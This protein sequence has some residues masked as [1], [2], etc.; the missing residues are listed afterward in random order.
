MHDDFLVIFG[1]LRPT[2]CNVLISLPLYVYVPY[3]KNIC[4][5]EHTLNTIDFFFFGCIT[6]FLITFNK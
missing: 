5:Y 2:T 6:I 4:V 1:F 3:K